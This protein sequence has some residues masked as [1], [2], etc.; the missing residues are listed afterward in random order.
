MKRNILI[1]C[2]GFNDSDDAKYLLELILTDSSDW[3]PREE[4]MIESAMMFGLLYHATIEEKQFGFTITSDLGNP[5]TPFSV[6]F[7]AGTD[8]K[9]AAKVVGEVADMLLTGEVG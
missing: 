7:P 3:S 8:T 4:A 2:S 5:E 9:L 6:S 1:P